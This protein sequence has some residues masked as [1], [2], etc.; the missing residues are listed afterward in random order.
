MGLLALVLDGLEVLSADHAWRLVV[1]VR[2]VLMP[3]ATADPLVPIR[4]LVGPVSWEGEQHCLRCGKVLVKQRHGSAES[5]LP[6]YV[7]EIGPRLT[8]KPSENY[9]VCG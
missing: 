8:S 7:F 5:L 9:R 6:G 4:H 2:R 3:E 1:E